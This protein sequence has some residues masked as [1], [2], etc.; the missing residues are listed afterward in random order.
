MAALYSN[1]NF[2]LRVVEALRALGHDV[3]TSM[4][5]GQAHQSIPDEQVLA[6][7]TTQGRILLTLNRRDFIRLHQSNP[8]HAGLIVCTQD[9]DAVGQANRI[10]QVI[11]GQATLAGQLL[12]VNRPL[13]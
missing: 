10:H 2:P 6:F 13:R 7:A 3:L 8:I 4:D 9:P 11:Q 12:R 1:E 5:A